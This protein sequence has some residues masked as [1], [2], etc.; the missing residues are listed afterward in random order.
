MLALTAQPRTTALNSRPVAAPEP[1]SVVVFNDH[2]VFRAGFSWKLSE[3]CGVEILANAESL[4]AAVE[5]V[6]VCEPDAVIAD[7]RICDG[8]REGIE[9]VETLARKFSG[10]PVIVYSDFYSSS[11]VQ[12]MEEAGAAAF[13]LKSAGPHRLA[14][15][16]RQAVA[17]RRA[18]SYTER[19]AA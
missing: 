11:Y 2:P 4:A 12:R 16:I 14:K 3:E 9:A 17:E 1:T 18:V 8:S 19:A 15:A 5:Q 6:S 7:L 13:V 10:Q